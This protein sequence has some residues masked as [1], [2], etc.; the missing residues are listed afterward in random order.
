MGR[1]ITRA[2]CNRGK[3]LGL[4]NH[5]VTVKFDEPPFHLKL[6]EEMCNC[7]SVTL[8]L[9]HA[10]GGGWLLSRFSSATPGVI[11]RGCWNLV[12]FSEIIWDI[13]CW[14]KF[15]IVLL[16]SCVSPFVHQS[17]VNFRSLFAHFLLSFIKT[18]RNRKFFAQNCDFLSSWILLYLSC[19]KFCPEGSF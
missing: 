15:S 17:S 2:S 16:F 7:N 3:R 14:K 11:S 5:N 6:V 8:T 4:I 13:F 10:R 19:S 1:N 9:C 18:T 12:T